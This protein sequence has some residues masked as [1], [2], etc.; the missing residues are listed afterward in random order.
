M[1]GA[2]D[3][4]VRERRVER[5]KHALRLNAS[6][7]FGFI[8][9]IDPLLFYRDSKGS[10]EESY[11][12]QLAIYLT[13]VALD[14]PETDITDALGRHHSTVAHACHIIENARSA[15]DAADDAIEELIED[16]RRN[17]ERRER[18]HN[19]LVAARDQGKKKS[20]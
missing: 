15:S 7:V 19:A 16:V 1:S 4:L 20:A 17:F 2:I 11:W 8:A 10:S 9:D 18:F 3:P 6:L 5:A 13:R 14:I 12:R